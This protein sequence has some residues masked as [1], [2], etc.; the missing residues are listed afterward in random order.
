MSNLGTAMSTLIATFICKKLSLDTVLYGA[1]MTV[2]TILIDKVPIPHI[3]SS[4]Y[5][6]ITVCAIL[7][8]GYYAICDIHTKCSSISIMDDDLIDVLISYMESCDYFDKTYTVEV[9]GLRSSKGIITQGNVMFRGLEY[10]V[11]G[12]VVTGATEKLTTQCPKIVITSGKL[13]ASEYFE[14]IK[15]A[16]AAKKSRM[17]V[18][19]SDRDFSYTLE[20]GQKNYMETFFSDAGQAMWR[21]IKNMDSTFYTT[22][23]QSTQLNFLLYGPPGTGKSNIVWRI[24]NSVIRV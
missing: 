2:C 21:K 16:M 12:Y 19:C 11:A 17:Y 22:I 10:N 5:M 18:R 15:S 13:T 9:R 7:A 20:M 8:L 3:N 14:R 6:I 24:A 23:G 4:M 1:I